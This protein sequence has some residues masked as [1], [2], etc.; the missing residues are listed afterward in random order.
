MRYIDYW[1]NT[2]KVPISQRKILEEMQS[3]NENRK[4]VIYSLNGLLK[5]GYI[6]RAITNGSGENGIGAEKTKYV[7]LRGV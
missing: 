3:V 2:Q 5:Q 6:R 1:A 4:T 7:K